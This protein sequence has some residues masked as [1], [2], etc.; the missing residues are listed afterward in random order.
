MVDF[1]IFI[2]LGESKMEIKLGFYD[3]EEA[4]KL[5]LKKVYGFDNVDIDYDC[6]GF[7]FEVR[8]LDNVYKKHKNGKFK[9][10]KNGYSILDAE[11]SKWIT[12]Y[13]SFG[14]CDELSFYV[15]EVSDE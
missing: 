12:K 8:E 9:K 11:K 6:S 5:H 3:L 1:I 13:F 7:N 10:D 4:I 15:K 14:E 2:K